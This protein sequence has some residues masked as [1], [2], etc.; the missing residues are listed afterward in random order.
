MPLTGS[1]CG[2]QAV[3]LISFEVVSF[4]PCD[5]CRPINIIVNR[6]INKKNYCDILVFPLKYDYG[7]NHYDSK[8]L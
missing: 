8:Q 7:M 4:Y 6:E 3:D 5:F 2:W 1:V